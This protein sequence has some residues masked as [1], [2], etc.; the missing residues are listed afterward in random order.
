MSDRYAGLALGRPRLDIPRLLPG[1]IIAGAAALTGA[2]AGLRPELAIVLALAAG[3]GF[4]VFADLAA[5][6][7]VFTLLT[8]FELL[9]S[10]SGPALSFTKVAGL[11][12]ALS[13][14]AT[15]ASRHDSANTDFF[16]A[17]TATAWFLAAFLAWAGFSAIWAESPSGAIEAVYRFALNATLFLI[18]FTAI[19]T[20]RDAIRVFAAFVI[21]ATAA[22]AYGFAFEVQP[23]AYGEAARLSGESQN[24]NELASTLV[25]ALALSVGLVAITRRSPMLRLATVLA[26]AIA[27]YG[28]LLTVSRAGVIALG[29]TLI[30]GVALAGR[31]R[32]R[33]VVVAVSIA[34]ATA[35][36]FAAIAA[37]EVRE[38]VTEPEGGTGRTDI[39]TVGW[40]MVEAQPVHGVGAGN[41]EV[42]SIHYLLAPGALQR[43][44]FIVDT[45]E[46]AHNVYLGV[47]AELGIVGLVLFLGLVGSVLVV[48]L[49][50][51]REFNRSGD[52]EMEILSRAY[53][54]ALLGFLASVFFASDEF[55]KQLWLLLSMSPALFAI[56]V[57]SRRDRNDAAGDR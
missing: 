15:I 45:P 19:G 8:F 50:A 6:V 9:P 10:T 27:T 39:W 4:L 35:I 21:G 38:R 55:K 12:L 23:A 2:L 57:R 24:A 11:V 18:V 46:V 7:A 20:R 28:I 52:L 44:E 41:F 36:Y 48:G 31:W 32:G 40:R 17:H 26:A 16:R 43:D 22:A 49:R 53:V 34:A 47:L 3:F 37:P 29:V 13:W 42:S 5:G 33:V 1:L 14:L 56:A 54:A 51:A 25:A 30:A